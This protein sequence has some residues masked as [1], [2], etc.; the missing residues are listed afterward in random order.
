MKERAVS[1]KD[2]LTSAVRKGLTQANAKRRFVKRSWSLG[3][4]QNF[5]WD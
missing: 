3:R 5:R 1:F 2:A 4:E